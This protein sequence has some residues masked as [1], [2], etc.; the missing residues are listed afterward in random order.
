MSADGGE[1]TG[2]LSFHLQIGLTRETVTV[3]QSEGGDLLMLKE[4]ACEFVD[5]KASIIEQKL[6]DSQC[7]LPFCQIVH[8]ICYCAIRF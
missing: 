4:I 2:S 8:I 1:K 7:H 5:R 3:E 6:K